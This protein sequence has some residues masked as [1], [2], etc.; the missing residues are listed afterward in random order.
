MPLFLN[1]SSNF[2]AK[3]VTSRPN[4]VF[5]SYLCQKFITLCLDIEE[6]VKVTIPDKDIRQFLFQQYAISE[7]LK[8]G[9][10]DK[11]LRR[12][13]ILACLDLGAGFRQLS[14][15]TGVPYGVIHRLF[16]KRQ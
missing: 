15:L 10:L 14:R 13:I 8:V 6:Q 5:F 7:P 12:D 16:N 9:T 3:Q 11:E 2:Y 4:F 1:I